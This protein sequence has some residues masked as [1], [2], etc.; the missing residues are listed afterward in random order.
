MNNL[1]ASGKRYRVILADPPWSYSNDGSSLDGLASSNYPTMPDEEICALPVNQIT[2][3]DA[4]LFLWGTSP[5][6]KEGIAVLE[7]WG[8]E[9]KTVGFFWLKTAW[10][11][12]GKPRMGLGYY[13][14]SSVEPCFLGTKGSIHRSIKARNV[15]QVIATPRREHSRKPEE[16][17]DRIEALFD[18]PYIELFARSQRPGWDAWGNETDKFGDPEGGIL[19]L[20]K[21]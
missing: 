15:P 13:T 2:E 3:K 20:G 4:V 10:G 16:I 6:L 19:P 9:F 21:P 12:S 17:Y 8:F 14:R 11:P 18:G 7:A 1:I 5:K